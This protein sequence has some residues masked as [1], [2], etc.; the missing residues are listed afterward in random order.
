M[1]LAIEPM[2]LKHLY[3]YMFA[4]PSLALASL[5]VPCATVLGMGCSWVVSEERYYARMDY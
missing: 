5:A 3:P 2:D 4:T 1:L